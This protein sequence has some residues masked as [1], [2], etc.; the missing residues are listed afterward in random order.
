MSAFRQKAD[1]VQK[2]FI[3]PL[4]AEI[5]QMSFPGDHQI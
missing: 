4:V 1:I 3:I 5:A 2:A